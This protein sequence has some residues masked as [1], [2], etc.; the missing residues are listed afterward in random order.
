M[1]GNVL[2]AV[3]ILAYGSLVSITAKSMPSGDYGVGYAF[4]WLISGTAFVV[5]GGLL[6]WYMNHHNNFDWAPDFF[7]RY[8]NW[9]VFLTWLA[10]SLALVWSLEYRTK[11]IDGK[12]PTFLRW[13]IQTKVYLWLPALILLPSLYLLNAQRPEGFAPIWIKLP[14]QIGFWVSIALGLVVLYGLVKSSVQRRIAH[15]AAVKEA[16]AADNNESW[17]FNKSMESIENYKDAGIQRLLTYTHREQ[18]ERIRA[19]A[20]AKIKTFANWE[21][22]LVDTLNQGAL[23][24]A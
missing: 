22:Q 7:L 15:A 20:L 24:E 16:K 4:V 12:F 6:A 13:F 21:A 18:D 14:I 5:S 19:A 9:M 2:I 10:F 8:Q 3:L 11:W 17:G 1:L 23:N